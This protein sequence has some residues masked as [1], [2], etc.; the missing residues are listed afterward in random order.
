MRLYCG[1]DLHSNNAYVAVLDERDRLYLRRYW[2]LEQDI[3]HAPGLFE[4]DGGVH[5]ATFGVAP[6]TVISQSSWKV[7][8]RADW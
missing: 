3:D 8:K 1:I 2:Q 4:P 6:S 7:M 5:R